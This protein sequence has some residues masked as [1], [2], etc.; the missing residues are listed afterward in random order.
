LENSYIV[1]KHKF[2]YANFMQFFINLNKENFLNSTRNIT[3]IFALKCENYSKI[4]IYST[5]LW[6]FLIDLF[7]L[8]KR[9][10]KWDHESRFIAIFIHVLDQ[11]KTLNVCIENVHFS[12]CQ[13][14]IMGF[15]VISFMWQGSKYFLVWTILKNYWQI[16]VRLFNKVFFLL[17]LMLNISCSAN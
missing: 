11:K 10:F 4:K 7:I 12:N 3:H 8:F 2:H 16:D 13:R 1:V 6:G 15:S 17:L 14:Q 5:F 9:Y